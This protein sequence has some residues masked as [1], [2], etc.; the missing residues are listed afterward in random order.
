MIMPYLR[1]LIHDHKIAETRSK[2]VNLIQMSMHVNF[3]SS[4]DAEQTRTIYLQ[5][6]NENIMW[7]NE[8]DDIIKELFESSL[9]NYQKEKQIMRA[10]N[11]FI[12]ESVEVM[13]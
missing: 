4:K 1:N 12:F 8:T 7:G 10:G 6:D 2:V 9:D 3:I 13:D 5:S 11:D